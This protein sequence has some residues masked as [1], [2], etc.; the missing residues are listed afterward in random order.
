[1][2]IYTDKATGQKIVEVTDISFLSE[3]EH[4]YNWFKRH[5]IH[6]RL[7]L[8]L[9]RVDKVIVHNSQTAENIHRF[10]FIPKDHIMIES[11]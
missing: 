3:R 8:A 6:H 2:K 10:Y 9:K 7:R 1:M 11:E 5:M 4:P